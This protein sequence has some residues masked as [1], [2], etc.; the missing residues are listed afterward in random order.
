M[1]EINNKNRINVILDEFGM[2]FPIRDIHNIITNCRS[3]NIRFTALVQNF[4]QI[5]Y[6]YGKKN[7]DLIRLCFANIIYLLTND[8]NTIHEVLDMCLLERS[9][10]NV[11]A[12]K[13]MNHFDCIIIRQRLLPFNSSLLPY[14]KMK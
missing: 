6:T 7:S 1:V 4:K 13:T 9:D 3:N 14:Y 2:L 8:I 11:V 5:D 10:E 12:L